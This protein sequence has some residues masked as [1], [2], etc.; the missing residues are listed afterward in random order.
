MRSL[1]RQGGVVAVEFVIVSAIAMS[2]VAIA[3]GLLADAFGHQI[4][5]LAR[6]DAQIAELRVLVAGF[7][8][9]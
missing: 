4:T 8:C 7:T 5:L 3:A 9:P 6:L 1:R 2:M